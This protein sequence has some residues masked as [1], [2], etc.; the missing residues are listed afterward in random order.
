MSD[1]QSSIYNILVIH[2][3]G[4]KW[5]KADNKDTFIGKNHFK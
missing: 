4:S 2:L 3:S 5:V 1:A